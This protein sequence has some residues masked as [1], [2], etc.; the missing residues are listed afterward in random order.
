MNLFFTLT[1]FIASCLTSLLAFPWMIQSFCFLIVHAWLLTIEASVRNCGCGFL[2]TREIKLSPKPPCTLEPF[3]PASLIEHL[4]E[5]CSC[6]PLPVSFSLPLLPT[7][8][9]AWMTAMKRSLISTAI[10]QG[11]RNEKIVPTVS[12]PYTAPHKC[13]QE[14]AIPSLT[15]YR[16]LWT[17]TIPITYRRGLW[18]S[19]VRNGV[20][21]FNGTQCLF[22]FS[23]V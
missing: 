7:A 21:E 12:L 11:T 22:N 20:E 23:P 19:R 6:C 4:H 10:F 8:F 1:W 5:S 16:D 3:S 14:T 13:W 18:I 2:T 17:R 9:C 15:F